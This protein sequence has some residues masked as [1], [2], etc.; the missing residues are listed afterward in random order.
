M[1]EGKQREAWEHGRGIL[2]SSEETGGLSGKDFLAREH[3]DLKDT[4][5]FYCIKRRKGIQTEGTRGEETHEQREGSGKRAA[6]K[7]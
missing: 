3:S 1:M 6:E 5:E 7:N 2:E 4:Y